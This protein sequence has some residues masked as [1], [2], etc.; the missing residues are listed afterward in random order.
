M[1]SDISR[2]HEELD[3]QPIPWTCVAIEFTLM[4]SSGAHKHP[5]LSRRVG[6]LRPPRSMDFRSPGREGD[7]LTRTNDMDLVDLFRNPGSL[8]HVSKVL[9]ERND[10]TA[11]PDNVQLGTNRV[12]QF[13]SPNSI[14]IRSVPVNIASLLRSCC[15]HAFKRSSS[16]D[17]SRRGTILSDTRRSPREAPD[18]AHHVRHPCTWTHR[19]VCHRPRC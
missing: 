8:M 5:G 4:L 14:W 1:I 9:I 18:A 16:M 15:W 6:V 11:F 17:P 3:E 10:P 19:H 2:R 7:P 12:I 13:S